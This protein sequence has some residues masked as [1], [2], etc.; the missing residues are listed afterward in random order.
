MYTYRSQDSSVSIVTRL[1][2]WQLGFDSWQR[3]PDQLWDP[4]SLLFNVYWGLFP[5]G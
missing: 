2:D 4:T 3:L 1:Q 5:S